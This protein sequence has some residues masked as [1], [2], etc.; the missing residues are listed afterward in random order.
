MWREV[1]TKT[2]P[3][4]SRGKMNPRF[5]RQRTG[6]RRTIHLN[7]LINGALN[8]VLNIGGVGEEEG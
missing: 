4:F 6:R 8:I 7:I 1:R 3:R 5:S 2:N